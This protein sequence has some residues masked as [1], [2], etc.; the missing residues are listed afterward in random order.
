MINFDKIFTFPYL[1]HPTIFSSSM[2]CLEGAPEYDLA[3]SDMFQ[4]F[5]NVLVF[6]KKKEM[7][8]IFGNLFIFYSGIY[9]FFATLCLPARGDQNVD[10]WSNMHVCLSSSLYSQI[11]FDFFYLNKNHSML[12]LCTF[13]ATSPPAQ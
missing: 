4:V 6:K 12:D 11:L 3:S 13:T 2:A 1:P 5:C 7:F 9:S 10:S 8:D